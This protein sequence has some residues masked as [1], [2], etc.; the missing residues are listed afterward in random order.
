M[1][2]RV[3]E[4]DVTAFLPYGLPPRLGRCPHCDAKP[5]SRAM[6]WYLGEK[7]GALVGRGCEVLE[8]GPSR[9][10]MRAHLA[11]L[12][13]VRYTAI[14]TRS[15]K[16]HASLTAPH[17]FL[18]MDVTRMRFADSAFDLILCNNVL[19]YVADFRQALAEL[20][21]CLKADGV[22]ILNTPMQGDTTCSARE[23]RAAHPGLGDDYFAE[24][25]D[26]WVYG[27]DLLAHIAGAGLQVRC[28]TP[29]AGSSAEF[30]RYHG[31]NA[32]TEFVLAARSAAGL[33][34]TTGGAE[35][36]EPR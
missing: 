30:L 1:F 29:L 4:N 19:P 2:C 31:L 17:R 12:G 34:P 5:R 13:R 18:R 26:Q 22:A 20:R 14:D 28:E 7:T 16:F 36:P 8:V 15:L 35:T 21:R 10:A 6:H 11:V 25:G 23:H 3:C 33:P 27:R 24:N 9:I 32:D